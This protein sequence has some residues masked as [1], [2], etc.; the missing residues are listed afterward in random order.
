MVLPTIAT[1]LPKPMFLL[2]NVPVA[3]LVERVTMSPVS[4]PTS[5]AELVV[6][7][8]VVLAL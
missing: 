3:L 7:V 2:A 5:V 8:A 1:A 6:S 4:F